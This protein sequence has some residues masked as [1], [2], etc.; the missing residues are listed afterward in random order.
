MVTPT[1]L[2]KEKKIQLSC[3]KNDFFSV[4]NFW[5]KGARI[6]LCPN[7]NIFLLLKSSQ[8]IDL[9]NEL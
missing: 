3:E 6:K 5:A 7:Q 1:K 8:I 4:L 9:E 2:P